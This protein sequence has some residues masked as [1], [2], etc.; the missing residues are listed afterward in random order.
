MDVAHSGA[1]RPHGRQ[2]PLKQPRPTPENTRV[3]TV[4]P[5][6][7]TFFQEEPGDLKPVFSHCP[8]PVVGALRAFTWSSV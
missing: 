4:I 2:G 5:E 7:T 1:L 6:I 3:K 8:Q